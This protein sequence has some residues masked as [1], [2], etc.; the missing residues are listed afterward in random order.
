MTKKRKNQT[1]AQE[2]V[3]KRIETVKEFAEKMGYSYNIYEYHAIIVNGWNPYGLKDGELCKC[4]QLED[5]PIDGDSE[6]YAWAWS[7][8]TGKEF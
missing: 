1:S 7:L 4:L 5:G 8:E 2:Y 6:H 3:N